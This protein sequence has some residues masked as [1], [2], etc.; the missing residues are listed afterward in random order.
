MKSQRKYIDK[1]TSQHNFLSLRR[2]Q[3]RNFKQNR[4]N[5]IWHME[6]YDRATKTNILKK[7]SNNSKQKICSYISLFMCAHQV[8]WKTDIFCGLCKKTKNVT[9]NDLFDTKC[10][11]FD[12]D[13]KMSVFYETTLAHR[14]FVRVRFFVQTFWNLQRVF[15][16]KLKNWEHM[17][18]GTSTTQ[19]HVYIY[20]YSNYAFM[21]RYN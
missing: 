9:I 5:L 6:S 13:T 19:N 8:S 15:K 4:R 3:S 2:T 1:C 16:V 18:R 11:L 7:M 21:N 12:D 20:L 17:L 14:M 10:C